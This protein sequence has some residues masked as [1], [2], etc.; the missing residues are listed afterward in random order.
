[1]QATQYVTIA[2]V[3]DPPDLQVMEDSVVQTLRFPP[4]PPTN[5]PL[6][7]QF[8]DEQTNKDGNLTSAVGSM[9]LLKHE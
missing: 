2:A 8:A 7:P 9:Y 4:P 1:M 5:I 6:Y 3:R